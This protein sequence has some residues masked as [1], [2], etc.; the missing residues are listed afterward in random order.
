M[1]KNT[2]R[3]IGLLVL[4]A[5]V[6]VGWLSFGPKSSESTAENKTVKVGIMSGSKNDDEI[7]DSVAKTAKDK[8]NI[9][10][11]FV[12]FTDYTQPNTALS[13]HSVDL[14]AFQH[15]AFLKDWNEKHHT[16]ITSIGDT[17]ITPIRL[18]SDKYKNVKDIPN[19]ATIAVPNDS[20]NESRALV[21]L[22]NAGLIELKNKDGL[23][24]LGD[25]TKNSKNLN[26]K[27]V[28]ASQTPRLLNSVDASV[29]NG[30]YA[31]TAKLPDN[32]SIF[33]EPLNKDSKPWVNFIAA[34]KDQKDNDTYKK[35]VKAYQTKKTAD[36]IAEKYGKTE[37][38]A[39]NHKFE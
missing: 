13:Q 19:G 33:T 35:V 28:D 37:V 30:N 3:I 29:V 21:L 18:F 6:A 22:K 10:L 5:I 36:L 2:K 9:N 12:H 38:P 8:Y 20:T 15:T 39:W 7:W 34:N 4:V 27:E 23:L 16:N 31:T 14:N 11:K 24:G 26:I 25:I 32:K 1:K 17:I